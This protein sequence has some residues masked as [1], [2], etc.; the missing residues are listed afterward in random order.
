MSAARSFYTTD[1][2]LKLYLHPT[3]STYVA[4]TTAPQSRSDWEKSVLTHASKPQV[5]SL[6]DV[7][8][9]MATSDA[10]CEV[11]AVVSW[12][13]LRGVF[14]TF[15]AT[16]EPDEMALRTS[17]SGPWT[18]QVESTPSRACSVQ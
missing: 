1:V 13:Q 17:Y 16:E 4:T 11:G 2:G 7:C 12:K 8:A 18:M 5:S 15:D 3:Y 14:Y 10:M 6:A 9:S